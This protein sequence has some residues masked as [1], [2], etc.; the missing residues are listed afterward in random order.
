MKTSKATIDKRTD[1]R[2][3][4]TLKLVAWELNELRAL[5][6]ALQLN[7][8]GQWIAVKLAPALEAIQNDPIKEKPDVVAKPD[9]NTPRDE[10]ATS[11]T[12]PV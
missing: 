11:T 6:A 8:M 2:Y 3:S 12:Q 9:P 10:P 7:P 5:I 4:V 1:G